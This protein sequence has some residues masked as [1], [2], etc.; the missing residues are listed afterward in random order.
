MSYYSLIVSPIYLPFQ[1]PFWSSEITF[2]RTVLSLAAINE[3]VISYTVFSKMIGLQFFRNCIIFF[4]LRSTNNNPLSLCDRDLAIVE[5][6]VNRSRRST[7]RHMVTGLPLTC[8]QVCSHGIR[9]IHMATGLLRCHRV[10]STGLLISYDN[11][12]IRTASGLLTWRQV[13]WHV[14]TDL[15]TWTAQ[16]WHVNRSIY[17]STGLLARLQVYPH[18][19]RS[20]HISSCR[21]NHMSSCRSTHTTP[22]LLAC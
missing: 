9:S 7:H 5:P 22:G 18:D 13:S 16:C 8:H 14:P 19:T 11:R 21:S 3:D 1:K 2:G 12:F 6:V 4:F 20:N 15:F 17:M 10:Y